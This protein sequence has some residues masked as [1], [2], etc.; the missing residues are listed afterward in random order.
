MVSF[1]HNGSK[2]PSVTAS[3]AAGNL[4][5]ESV[6]KLSYQRDVSSSSVS[7]L[8][9]SHSGSGPRS[10]LLCLH[11]D[12]SL[13]QNAGGTAATCPLGPRCVVCSDPSCLGGEGFTPAEWLDMARV[14]G[15]HKNVKNLSFLLLFGI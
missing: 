15:Q 12:A 10:L 8:G 13:F 1:D 6:Q 5:L 11:P 3:T 9:S 2:G 14:A 7:T 4:F